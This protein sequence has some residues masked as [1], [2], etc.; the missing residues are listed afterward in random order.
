VTIGTTVI[1]ASFC[2]SVML[3]DEILHFYVPGLTNIQFDNT[4]NNRLM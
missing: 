4:D 3:C 1:R 2:I